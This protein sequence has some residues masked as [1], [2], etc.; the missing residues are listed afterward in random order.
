MLRSFILVCFFLFFG[1]VSKAQT[2]LVFNGD[3]EQYSSCPTGPS[4]P[5]QNP[6]YEITKCLGWTTP[7]AATSD[8]LH[9]C[10]SSQVQIPN[11]NM[12]WQYAHSGNGYCGFLAINLPDNWFEY[13]RGQTTQ[14]L[15]GG[16]Q[17]Q[18]SFYASMGDYSKYAVSRIGAYI[19]SS[20]IS[21]NDTYPFNNY[22]P[23]IKN[24]T[25]NYL[26]DTANWVLISGIYN[27]AG[28]EQFITIG[29]YT[30]T[31]LLG[32]TLNTFPPG[33]TDNSYYFIDDVSVTDLTVI[34]ESPCANKLLDSIP[35]IITPN[36][37]D[38]NEGWKISDTCFIVNKIIIYD[39]WGIKIFETTRSA[40]AWDGHTTSGLPCSEGIYYFIISYSD[41]TQKNF[42]KNGFIQ[43][44]H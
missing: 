18:V 4:Y 34:T 24:P 8:Y 22:S 6:N 11:N 41:S 32:D 43:L 20:P 23:Q 9:V 40:E 3:F 19:S 44:T 37:D 38:R 13:I 36:G 27:A 15:I 33:S 2:N 17:Y 29:N 35:N 7:T 25:G 31:T 14:P 1:F 16:H 5:A 10:G 12:G 30:D 28:G 39:R 42:T 21:R 26:N